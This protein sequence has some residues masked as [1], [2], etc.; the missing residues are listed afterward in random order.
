MR[1]NRDGCWG[2]G[3][4]RIDFPGVVMVIADDEGGQEELEDEDEAAILTMSG[5]IITC[6]TFRVASKHQIWLSFV[7]PPPQIWNY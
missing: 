5:A 7:E 6:T 1:E 3:R 2:G 4:F